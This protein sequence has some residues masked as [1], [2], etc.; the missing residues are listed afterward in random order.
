MTSLRLVLPPACLATGPCVAWLGLHA[1]T[2]KA[3]Q[4]LRRVR[5]LLTGALAGVSG[6]AVNPFPLPAGLFGR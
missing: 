1:P 4:I 2:A 5:L 3:P 6:E